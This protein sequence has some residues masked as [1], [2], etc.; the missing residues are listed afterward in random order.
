[1]LFVY[2]NLHCNAISIV[3]KNKQINP[4]TKQQQNKLLL[5]ALFNIVCI[6]TL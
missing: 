3:F 1:M 2:F 5:Y 6:T 4:E